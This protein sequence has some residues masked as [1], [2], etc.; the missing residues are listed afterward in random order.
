MS[1]VP[2][3][4]V[5]PRGLTAGTVEATVLEVSGRD[6]IKVRTSSDRR[7]GALARKDGE[8][9]AAA[10]RLARA[11]RLPLI[12]QLSSS[13]ADVSDGI[14]AL[15]G[16]G[17][18]AASLSECSGHV[19]VITVVFGPVLSGPAFLLGLSDLVIMT[20]AAMTFVSG[21]AMVEAFTGV[22]MGHRDLGGAGVHAL[23]SGL[24]ALLST[25]PDAAVAELLGFLPSHADELPPR[26]P[27][28]DPPDRIVPEL[29]DVVPPLERSSYDVRD[30]VR[31]VADDG[32]QVELWEQWA[33]QLVTALVRLGGRSVGVVANQPRSL[34]GTLD[35]AASQKGAR[36]VNLCDAFNLPILTFVDTPGFLPGKGL[37]WRGMIRHGAE[38]VFAY[39]QASVPRVCVI[40]RK[41]FGGAYIVMDSK[42]VGNDLCL[43][44]PSAEVAVMGARGAA[45]ILYRHRNDDERARLEEDYRARF[46]TPWSAA[47]RG[48]VDAVIDPAQTR[49]VLVRALDA[50]ATKR[51]R[52]SGRK[53]ETGPL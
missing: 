20:P 18:A 41:A 32:Y 10:A 28:V 43:A 46:L 17:S 50:L 26:S 44:W 23:A 8:T 39:S 13:G 52:L 7:R 1:A 27:R 19:P 14:D 40:L 48:F 35:I 33:P 12:L 47:A 29:R 53:H 4:T 22:R 34:A 25:D 21:P 11:Q 49:S 36:F 16:W 45:Q 15:H 6:T 9:L 42:G 24:C 37:E 30:V 38:L 2:A 3:V 51:E 31:R 5:R